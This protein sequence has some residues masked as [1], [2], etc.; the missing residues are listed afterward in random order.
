MLGTLAL[1]LVATCT[2]LCYGAGPGILL[3]RPT[4]TSIAMSLLCEVPTRVR[5]EYWADG[6]F[7]SHWTGDV[8]IATDEPAV[9]ELVELN[10]D[11]SYAYKLW[12][13]P[14]ES[15]PHTIAAE[16]Q[17]HTQRAVGSTFVF[18]VH[19]DPH[20]DDSTDPALYRQTLANTLADAPDFL[21]D[22]GDT[23]MSDKLQRIDP[24]TIE[25]RVRLLRTQYERL[26]HSVPT[27]LVLGNH[28]G[29]AAR[30]LDGT[31]ENLAVWGT[32]LR[33]TFFPNPSADA[34]YTGDE[35]DYAFVGQRESVYAWTW[36]DALFVVLDP[37]WHTD[38][39]E[40]REVGNWSR[41]LGADQFR[42]LADTLRGSDA[43]Y[44]FVFTHQLVGG[45]GQAGRGGVEAV[46]YYEMGGL[47]ADGSWGFDENRPGWEMPLHQL[48]VNTGVSVVF[49]GHDH[50]YAKQE[51]D[52][53]TYQLAPQPG[54]ADRSSTV[55]SGR[56]GYHDGVLLPASGH[57]RVTVAAEAASVE[58]VRAATPDMHAS[59]T[60][61]TVADSYTV[62]PYREPVK[63]SFPGS[64]ILGRPTDRSITINLLSE[65]ELE[66]WVEL[67]TARGAFEAYGAAVTVVQG[68]PAELEVN[69]LAPDSDGTYR[70]R[71]RRP[72]ERIS[73]VTEPE[74]FHTQRARGQG[75]TFTIQ[76]DSHLGTL[77]HCEP[78]LYAQTLR[79]VAADSPD[80]HIDLGDTFRATHLKE[81]TPETVARTDIDQ[82]AYFDLVA[83]SAP[84]FLVLGNHEG[85]AGWLNDGTADNM[86]IWATNSR[87]LYYPNPEPNE[88]Y[89]GNDDQMA[90]VGLLENYYAWEWGDA[91]FA[92]LDPW[93]YTTGPF[94]SDDP[95]HGPGDLWSY[96]LGD[97]QYRWL[98]DT[99]RQSESIFKF[100][101]AHH[102]IGSC[103]G[104]AR[105]AEY[106][107]WGGH[108]RNGT[109]AFDA[110][111]PGWALPVH[112]LFVDTGVTIFFQGHD[113]LFAQEELDGVIYQTVPMPGDTTTSVGAANAASYPSATLLPNSGHLRVS[114]SADQVIVEY[115]RAWLPEAEAED[116]MNGETA[117]RYVV[118]A[119]T[120]E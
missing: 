74:T 92:V 113:H 49:H 99:L 107:E 9:I 106:F 54:F 55:E 101:F 81:V 56:D 114:V 82:R 12:T 47:N 105:W 90:Y 32:L 51:L 89:T 88:F 115:V 95:G 39:R 35:T 41:T 79:N 22:L 77:K 76:A 116:H 83:R 104:A 23:F 61:A 19:A 53:V 69:G 63:A 48:F 13:S 109:W 10:P 72:D 52:G 103:R 27:Y 94:D 4:D 68:I 24:S 75:F 28:E 37:Y 86:A 7:G 42:W 87:K 65:E 20:L 98:D 62:L 33:K 50:F 36:G 93:R 117:W 3:G 97:A 57:L 71:F 118:K 119:P 46:P 21:I 31:G 84:L 16:G 29:E 38:E 64:I 26:G 11:S 8:T 78:A 59:W 17:F 110:R 6:E 44:K 2:A 91:L 102:V 85:E 96:T 18:A 111:R 80:F 43:A 14:D 67:E 100:V 15:E 120:L 70:I 34:F 25:D 5:V 58:Y 40:T 73:L 1:V 112:D 108:D 45:I 60:N 66:V 30:H